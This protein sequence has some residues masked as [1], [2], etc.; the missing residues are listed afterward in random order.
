MFND[1]HD[2]TI[3]FAV[4]DYWLVPLLNDTNQDTNFNDNRTLT[5]LTF[6]ETETHRQQP[7]PRHTTWGLGSLDCSNMTST[8]LGPLN[9]QYNVLIT[10]LNPSAI[11]AGDG[12]VLVASGAD[13][14]FAA[15]YAPAP[16]RPDRS[17]KDGAV[18]RPPRCSG[19]VQNIVQ[20]QR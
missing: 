10:A 9:V 11:G 13:I 16:R 3:D 12:P 20:W 15:A 7:H 4:V 1:I 14:S 18:A 17:G 6:D 8:I 5:L 19:V 2:T